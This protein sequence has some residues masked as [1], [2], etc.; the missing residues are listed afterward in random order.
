[1]GGSPPE[2]NLQEEVPSEVEVLDA[3]EGPEGV[4]DALKKEDVKE[5]EEEEEEGEEGSEDSVTY[6]WTPDQQAAIDFAASGQSFYLCGRA[7]TGKTVVLNHIVKTLRRADKE[8]AVTAMTGAAACLLDSGRTLHSWASLPPADGKPLHEIMLKMGKKARE[9]WRDTHTLIVD[10][11]SMMSE[12]IIDNLFKLATQLRYPQNYPDI[13]PEDFEFFGGLQIILVGDLHQLPPVKGSP[14]YISSY[15]SQIAMKTT[16]LKKIF[17]QTHSQTLEVLEQIRLSKVSQSSLEFLK[18]LEKTVLEEN[19]KTILT[20]LRRTEEGINREKQNSL[21]TK[22]RIFKARDWGDRTQFELSLAPEIELKIGARVMCLKNNGLAGG[23]RLVNGSCGTIIKWISGRSSY[24]EAFREKQQTMPLDYYTEGVLVRWDADGM[25]SVIRRFDEEKE[26]A[27]GKIAFTRAQLPL[28]LAWAITIHKSQGMTLEN[29]EVDLHGCF[30]TGQVYVALSRC[31]SLEKTK[32]LNFSRNLVKSDPEVIAFY[33]R[34]AGEK[35]E[36]PT[37]PQI[38]QGKPGRKVPVPF[39]MKKVPTPFTPGA[40]VPAVTPVVA[41][42]VGGSSYV[43][44]MPPIP[45]TQPGDVQRAAAAK[46]KREEDNLSGRVVPTMFQKNQQPQKPATPIPGASLSGHGYGVMYD[47]MR[48]TQPIRPFPYGPVTQTGQN[49]QNRHVQNAQ[50]QNR[51]TQPA[52]ADRQQKQD[53]RQPRAETR[54]GCDA[55]RPTFGGLLDIGAPVVGTQ[56]QVTANAL[57]G[58]VGTQPHAEGESEQKR[59]RLG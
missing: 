39:V 12:E 46:R 16:L 40:V 14:I 52:F 36:T 4:L 58:V 57:R 23:R 55:I 47:T 38:G 6:E 48:N 27:R 19:K 2:V 31:K 9:R 20:S 43:G 42:V 5:E 30:D 7:G 37:R 15:F 1:M 17:R 49:G 56:P 51:P 34:I 3:P 8:V 41:P 44:D 21:R 35:P 28:R 25:E 29:V 26:N 45:V 50:P 53:I 33:R 11:C 32:V 10:E 24:V 13:S 22:G 54:V 59:Q 18:T